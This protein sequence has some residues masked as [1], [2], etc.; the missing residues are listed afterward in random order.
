MYRRILKQKHYKGVDISKKA[1]RTSYDVRYR[2]AEP[3]SRLT[4]WLHVYG[5]SE[6]T[7]TLFTLHAGSVYFRIIVVCSVFW[8]VLWLSDISYS[9]SA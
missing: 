3:N 5:D 7:L 6:V 8:C 2:C 9:K 1:D 4:L